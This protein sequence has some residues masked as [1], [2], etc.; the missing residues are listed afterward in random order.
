M[1]KCLICNSETNLKEFINFGNFPY[2][3][4]P[5]N[6]KQ[7]NKYVKKKNL[8]KKIRSDLNL[9][10]CKTCNYLKIKK[11]PNNKI[12][13]KIYEQFYTYPSPL[14][15]NF[16]PVRDNKFLEILNKYLKKTL[17]K[18]IFEVGCYDGYIL[19]QLK[20]KQYIVEGCEPSDGA[21]IAKKNGL[22]VFKGFFNKKKYIGKS[23]DLIVIRHTLEHIYNLKKIITDL[24]SV[25]KE[26][27][28]LIVEV[29]NIQY[30]L[31]KGL[32]EVFSLQHLHYFSI[33]TFVNICKRFGL[34]IIQYNET[35]ENLIVF[36]KKQ[37]VFKSNLKIKKVSYLNSFKKKI[38]FNRKK[39][40]KILKKY[41]NK[42]IIFWGAGG[43][44]FAALY[45]YKMSINEKSIFI[46]KDKK[47][48]NLVFYDKKIAIKS[49]KI[50]NRVKPDLIV[51]TSYYSS[52]IVSE[53]KKLKIKTK[54]LK[55]FPDIKLTN[56]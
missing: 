6:Y 33:K 56:N 25:M 22:N 34:G 7:F 20:K 45:L 32:L 50:L 54:I 3:N 39:I 43:F 23:Y 41:K 17:V 49:T 48:H 35:P 29:P 14:E 55:I 2:A 38:F 37:K 53:I 4:F 47:K 11:N 46:D 31:K 51:V 26:N 40:G 12:L 9:Q 24:K 52:L 19:H 28:T 8:S 18:T 16:D 30:Y 42:K 15:E 1:T 27:S 5:V 13:E 21:D 10:S 36:F 44:A